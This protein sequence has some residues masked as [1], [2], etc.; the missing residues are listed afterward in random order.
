M[1]NTNGILNYVKQKSLKNYFGSSHDFFKLFPEDDFD[2]SDSNYEYFLYFDKEEGEAFLLDFLYFIKTN[3]AKEV[4]TYEN[5]FSIF[6]EFKNFLEKN[7]VFFY[8]KT[9]MGLNIAN[10]SNASLL[11]TLKNAFGDTH[12]ASDEKKIAFN[13]IVVNNKEQY[14][15]EFFNFATKKLDGYNNYKYITEPLLQQDCEKI[16]NFYKGF[17]LNTKV[18]F[19]LDSSLPYAKENKKLL[20]EKFVV[21]S[22]ERAYVISKDNA[23]KCLV[24]ANIEGMVAEI[25]I[26][27]DSEYYDSELYDPI[28]FI[29]KHLFD[30]YD[31]KKI[32]T[33]NENKGISFSGINSALTISSF[34][35]D[36]SLNS[37]KNGYTKIKYELTREKFNELTVNIDNSL[38]RF[39]Y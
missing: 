22:P 30:N 21:A 6:D 28:L 32:I 38:I 37:D 4:F 7:K 19:F 11:S 18:P 25:D 34:S 26:V 24:I 39:V 29:C 27:C 35:P 9:K 13:E 10:Y 15:Y 2:F 36:Y 31:I 3:Y 1:D 8:S 33:I 14:T 12:F 5:Y 20:L 16:R 23:I 17:P